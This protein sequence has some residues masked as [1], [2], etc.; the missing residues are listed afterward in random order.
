M[1]ANDSVTHL[2]IVLAML[3]IILTDRR[4]LGY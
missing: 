1:V 2:V 3:V 4:V